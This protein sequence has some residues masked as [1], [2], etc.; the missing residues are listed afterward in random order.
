MQT[1]TINDAIEGPTLTTLRWVP[2]FVVGLVRDLR[3]R[4]A[5]E[6][7]GRA[8]AVRV[9][10]QEDQA[11]VAYRQQQPF[12]QVPVYQEPG[13]TLFESGA[14]LLHLARDCET[15]MPADEAGRAHTTEWIIAGLNSIEPHVQNFAELDFF[16]AG[17]A[18]AA[19]RRPALL[20]RLEQ[21]LGDLSKW[22]KGRDYL[23]G[24][25]T[26]AD[27]LMT[28]V[29]RT[30]RNTDVLT[31]FPVLEAYRDRCT[32]RPAFVKALADHTALFEAATPPAR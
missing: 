16:A 11:S 17:E 9:V 20:A 21:R 10:G 1:L 14:I 26:A 15:L 28:T 5:M 32:V 7:A 2:P 30:L 23:T 27:I 12:G 13:I 29:L 19:E 24:R 6:E 8:Y 3:V 31:R 22:L 4:W 18:W 25:F